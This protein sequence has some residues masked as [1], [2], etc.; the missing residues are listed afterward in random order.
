MSLTIG[1][2][3]MIE[4]LKYINFELVKGSM[5]IAWKGF[6]LQVIKHKTVALKT[7]LVLISLVC[8]YVVLESGLSREDARE[9]T[10]L[11]MWKSQ[12]YSVQ[13]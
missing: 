6:V 4:D 13:P 12:G 2:A 7:A 5:L 9:E 11:K 10:T 1:T 8:F 3:R